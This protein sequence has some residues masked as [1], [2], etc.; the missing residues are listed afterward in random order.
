M[1]YIDDNSAEF[2]KNF[3]DI[4]SVIAM[5]INDNHFQLHFKNGIR[6]Y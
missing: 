6:Y 4:C 3:V 5:V 1:I 2:Q